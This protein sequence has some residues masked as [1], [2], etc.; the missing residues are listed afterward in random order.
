MLRYESVEPVQQIERTQ[1][2]DHRG[3]LQRLAAL[4]ALYGRLPDGCLVS[5]L[6]LGQIAREAVLRQAPAQLGKHPR[7]GESV[8]D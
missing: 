5:Q 1:Q 7:I 3:H 8:S 2:P 6:G 4:G